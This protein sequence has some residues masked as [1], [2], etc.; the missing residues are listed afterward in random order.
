MKFYHTIEFK[1][2]AR[3]WDCRLRDS[4]FIDAEVLKSGKR[5]LKETAD[6]VFRWARDELVKDSKLEYFRNITH[7]VCKTDFIDPLDLTVMTMRGD[8]FSIN[9]I[10]ECNSINR[11]TVTFIIRRYEHKWGLRFWTLKQ[12]NLKHE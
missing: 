12:R 8:G 11:H 2:L 1:E 4:G 6:F 5:V 10:A 9:E 7:S 3:E